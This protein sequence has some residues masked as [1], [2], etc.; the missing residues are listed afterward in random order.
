MCLK[1]YSPKPDKRNNKAK[2]QNSKNKDAEGQP[3]TERSGRESKVSQHTEV[4]WTSNMSY[5]R[6]GTPRGL[7][8]TDVD[9][10][11]HRSSSQLSLIPHYQRSPRIIP[12]VHGYRGPENQPSLVQ[13][14]PRK[15]Y[16][17][18]QFV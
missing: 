16:H 5:S 2:P 15:K 11:Y 13:I 18:L 6:S 12:D 7:T 1:V 8:P 4:S 9:V 10:D 14:P 17:P 3:M